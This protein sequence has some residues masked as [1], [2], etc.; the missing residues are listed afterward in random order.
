MYIDHS[1]FVSAENS[2]MNLENLNQKSETMQTV[3]AE[4]K[5]IVS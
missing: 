3:D 5:K 4:F 1:L 2:V